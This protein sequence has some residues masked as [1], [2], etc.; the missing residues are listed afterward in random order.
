MFDSSPENIRVG[1]Y[2]NCLIIFMFISG[3]VDIFLLVSFR[4][5]FFLNTYYR[6]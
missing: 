1:A 5:I 3:L 4:K 6:F 2:S